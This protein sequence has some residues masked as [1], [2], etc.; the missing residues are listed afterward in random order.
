MTETAADLKR[1]NAEMYA[2]LAAINCAVIQD[3]AALAEVTAWFD[4][5]KHMLDPF[6]A[7]LFK[8]MAEITTNGEPPS[9]M[10]IAKRMLD[11]R[12][13]YQE[14]MTRLGELIG[15]STSQGAHIRFYCREV[16]DFYRARAATDEATTAI[17]DL[18]E[19]NDVDPPLERLGGLPQRLRPPEQTRARDVS[20]AFDEV[21]DELDG[22]R[23]NQGFSTGIKSLDDGIG[24]LNRGSFV[25]IGAAT[26]CG[27]STLMCQLAVQV[28]CGGDAVALVFSLEMTA[29]ELILRWGSYFSG[30]TRNDRRALMGGLSKVSGLVKDSKTLHIF[31]GPRT[32]T[33]I[34]AESRSYCNQ[35]NVGIIVV[36]YLQL[37]IADKSIREREQQVADVSRRLKLLAMGANTVVVAG[38]QLNRA[39]Q[40]KPTLSSLR[41]SGAIEQDS[42]V[43][44]LLRPDEG[45]VTAKKLTIAVAK[46]RNGP[47]MS[48]DAIW[49]RSLF[50]IRE[51]DEYDMPNY[52]SQLTFD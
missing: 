2:C 5:S 21:I 33:S 50:R 16:Y 35:M 42:D 29:A 24:R 43:V 8:A 6:Y 38:S 18:A 22:R 20:V 28:A 44:L 27:K 32:I 14:T 19:G 45:G 47:K 9:A 4:P 41:E 15:E 51:C 36:D 12:V 34:E 52:D 25:I 1:Q 30:V 10:A 48:I 39:G 7:D 11:C 46:Q 23:E 49:D 17:S 26:S 13:E 3:H 37:I 31:T 40:E